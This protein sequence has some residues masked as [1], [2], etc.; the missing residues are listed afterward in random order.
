MHYGVMFSRQRR[1]KTAWFI[2]SLAAAAIRALTA[3]GHA[4]PLCFARPRRPASGYA[5][6]A[7]AFPKVSVNILYQ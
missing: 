6:A 3:Q 4:S 2:V 1:E 5:A 7:L